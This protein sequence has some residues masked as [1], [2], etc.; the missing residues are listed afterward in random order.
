M[1]YLSHRLF[2]ILYFAKN[3]KALMRE[4]ARKSFI[5]TTQLIE[6]GRARKE[7]EQED[8]PPIKDVMDRRFA[9]LMHSQII[10]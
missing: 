2:G 3:H 1:R 6:R 8:T 10:E 9:A 7:S 4:N 5:H